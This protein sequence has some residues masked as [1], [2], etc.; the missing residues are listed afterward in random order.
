MFAFL[1]KMDLLEIISNGSV[2]QTLDICGFT[3]SPTLALTT[4]PFFNHPQQS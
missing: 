2:E 4:D 1:V 3:P